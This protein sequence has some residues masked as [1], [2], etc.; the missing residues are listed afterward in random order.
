MAV[1]FLKID[2]GIIANIHRD[3][4]CLAKAR[5]ITR[6]AHLTKR[7]TIAE[8]VETQDTLDLLREIR[9]DYVQGFGIARPRALAELERKEGEE[10]EVDI[11]P[12]SGAEPET[13]VLKELELSAIRIPNGENQTS[14]A[15]RKAIDGRG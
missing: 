13:R 11:S 1:N 9:V 8:F 15:E 2:G 5:A 14:I 4:V 10:N 7:Y 6:A 3:P 12:V